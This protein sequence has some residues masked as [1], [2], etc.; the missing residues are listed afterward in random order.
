MQHFEETVQLVTPER[1]ESEVPCG[2]EVEPY[3][4]ATREVIEAGA[5]HVYFHQIG[6]DQ[7][8]FVEFWEDE[9]GEA[10]ADLA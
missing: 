3:V 7:E 10:L 6:S 9:L 1:I 5:D 2:P 4:E 8:G